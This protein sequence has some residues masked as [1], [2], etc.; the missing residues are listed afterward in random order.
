MFWT[1]W[2]SRSVYIQEQEWKLLTRLEKT[3]TF[4]FNA[5]PSMK[6]SDPTPPPSAPHEPVDPNKL[7]G[8]MMDGEKSSICLFR[9]I[10]GMCCEHHAEMPWTYE[11][12]DNKL[13]KCSKQATHT[14]QHYIHAALGGVALHPSVNAIHECGLAYR[15]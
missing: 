5:M 2:S 7:L 8:I 4:G 12:V 1:K 15:A 10:R 13:R 11:C 3:I 6:S 9:E 14:S